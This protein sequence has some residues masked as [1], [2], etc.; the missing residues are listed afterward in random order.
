MRAEWLIASGESEASI[1]DLTA[2]VESTRNFPGVEE[3]A[4]VLLGDLEGNLA[5][6]G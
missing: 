2:V 1:P 4:R 3:R 5:G 6:A